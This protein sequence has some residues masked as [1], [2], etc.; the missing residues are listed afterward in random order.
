M[1]SSRGGLK[2]EELPA[3]SEKRPKSD[4]GMS[5]HTETKELQTIRTGINFGKVGYV[6]SE[7]KQTQLQ[8][9]Q[10]VH[11]VFLASMTMTWNMMI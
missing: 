11:P 6:L 10:I 7:S 8:L 1:C 4:H 9:R 5:N 2:I 3:T